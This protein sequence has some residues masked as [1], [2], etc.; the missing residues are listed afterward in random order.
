MKLQ[1]ITSVSKDYWYETAQYCIPNW[2]LPGDLLIYIDYPEGEIDWLTDIKFNK[3]LLHVPCLQGYEE[4][5]LTTKV[6][7]FWGKASA[8]IHAVKN[9]LEDTRII[10]L[11]ADVEQIKP[12]PADYF[13]SS[14]KHELALMRS[15][16][17]QKDCF[18]TGLVIFNQEHEKL[19][20]V[21][22]KYEKFWYESLDKVNKP[23]DAYVLGAVA[24]ERRFT[25]LVDKYCDNKDAFANSRFKDFFIHHINKENK[26]IFK[27]NK[28]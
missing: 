8:Q 2:N 28:L 19:N 1:F 15:N 26:R 5:D 16:Y 6:R 25:N 7:K 12:I 18:E 10:W 22:K 9:R 17:V 21:I 14:F 3:R 11:D 24:T 23:Y 27:D 20:V 13:N 4:L